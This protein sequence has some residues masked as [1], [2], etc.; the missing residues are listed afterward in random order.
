M[1]DS[2]T[3]EEIISDTGQYIKTQWK[4]VFVSF[5]VQSEHL[6]TILFNPFVLASVSDSVNILLNRHCRTPQKSY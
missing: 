6:H 1:S 4:S 5:P 3:N 2:E